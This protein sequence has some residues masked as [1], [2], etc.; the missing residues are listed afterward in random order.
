MSG[1]L[2]N[3]QE[4]AAKRSATNCSL[5]PFVSPSHKVGD[6]YCTHDINNIH[7]HEDAI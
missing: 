1:G 7:Q 5:L 3:I 4:Y 2:L 6:V